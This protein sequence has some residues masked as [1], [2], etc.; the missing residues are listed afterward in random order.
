MGL[1]YHLIPFYRDFSLL[2]LALALS[3]RSWLLALSFGSWL[4]ALS[5]SLSTLALGSG[6][7]F[8]SQLWLLL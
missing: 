6:S 8:V 7:G 1:E 4:L 2:A 5:S 3:S